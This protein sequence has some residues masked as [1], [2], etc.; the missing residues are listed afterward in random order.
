M[1]REP[2]KPGAHTQD[3]VLGTVS[4]RGFLKGSV[5]GIAIFVTFGPTMAGAAPS[6]ASSGVVPKDFNAF[7]RIG[8]DGRVTCLTG[9][10]EMGQGPITSLPQMLADELDVTYESVDIVMGDT[11]LCPWDMGTW[12]SLTTRAFGPLLRA[13]GAEAR[14]VLVELG[15]EALGVPVS[16]LRTRDGEVFDSKSPKRR[17]SYAALA[18]GKP[19]TRHLTVEPTPKK[20]SEFRIMGKP[21]LRRD[22]LDKVT[23]RAKYAGDV[24]L[25]GMLYAS[26]LR[27]PA[28]GAKLTKLDTSGARSMPGVRVVEVG[29]LVAVLH[30]L[31]DM[32]QEARRRIR[33]D[34][35]SP[36]TDVS[37]DNIHAYLRTVAPRGGASSERGNLAKGRKLAKHVVE[38]TYLDSYV[39]HA[40]ME[41][42]AAL[43]TIENGK[44]TVWASTQNPFGARD[45]IAQAIGLRPEAV[46]VITPFV[47]G[48]FGG[49]TTNA[50]AVE[51][52]LLAKAA[53]QPVQV[54]RTR[55]EE[56]F[57]DTFR[58]AAVVD[59]RS[60]I[61]ESGRVTFWDYD[62]LFAGQRGAEH[63]YDVPHQRTVARPPGPR[64]DRGTH[65]FATGAWRAPG[66]STNTFARESQIDEMAAAAGADPVEFRLKHLSDRRMI[67]VLKAAAKRFGWRPGVSPTKRGQGVA[68]GIDAGTYVCA[69]AEV[70]VDEQTGRVDV[71]RVVCAQDMG[72]VVNPQGA[73][74]Q[75]EGCITMGLG[76]TLSEEI[77]FRGGDILDTNFDRYEIPRFSSL[78]EIDTLIVEADDLPPQGG[79]EPAIVVMGGV[80]A[81]AIH[82]ATGARVLHMPMTPARVEA[83]IRRISQGG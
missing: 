56:F 48:G 54:M 13:A 16:R 19:I 10:I 32:A 20:V 82:D 66:N 79:G 17:I 34:F 57:Y 49:K 55:E 68:C 83:A 29:D 45:T 77:H 2:T 36:K 58:P 38:L 46:R 64:A 42:H 22:S 25:P 8:E 40:P 31:P 11:D 23:G 61:D 71:R 27:P 74:I 14:A 50:Q 44:C 60:G 81:N 4:R 52:A 18:K 1:S 7:L 30:E 76:Y 53:G 51:A 5:G 15:S 75:M 47:G 62:V 12:G 67:R 78:P 39:A 43:A 26:L 65:F 35:T 37:D 33:A 59:I 70:A 6:E 80:I 41:T 3:E 73:T 69:M 9:K 24:R 21:K 63:F 28:H 72:L